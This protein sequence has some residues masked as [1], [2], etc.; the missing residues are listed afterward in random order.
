MEKK[1]CEKVRKKDE[2]KMDY[3]KQAEKKKNESYL[4]NQDYCPHLCCYTRKFE[5]A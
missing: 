3:E 1:R 2:R 5:Q 4:H